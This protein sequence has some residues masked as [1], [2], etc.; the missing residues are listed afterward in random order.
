M[1][2]VRLHA[3]TSTARAVIDQHGPVFEVL[4]EA[5]YMGE[6]AMCLRAERVR[7]CCGGRRWRWEGWVRDSEATAEELF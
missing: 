7:S 4:R 6:A 5:M 2:R 3:R 1:R